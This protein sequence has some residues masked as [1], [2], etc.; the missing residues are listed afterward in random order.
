MV[1][2][3]LICFIIIIVVDE[4]CPFSRLG[5]I[6]MYH[7][8]CRRAAISTP[9]GRIRPRRRGMLLLSFRFMNLK[10][11]ESACNPLSEYTVY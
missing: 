5:P 8:D 3:A 6:T 11:S 9:V 4:T 7:V 2:D 10:F 1:A